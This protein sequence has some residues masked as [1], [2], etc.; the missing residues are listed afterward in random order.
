MPVPFFL[1][2]YLVPLFTAVLRA[3][4]E[5]QQQRGIQYPRATREAET[6]QRFGVSRSRQT[7]FS[8]VRRFA[9]GSFL[10]RWYLE[11]T[12]SS[13]LPADGRSNGC[14]AA[15]HHVEQVWLLQSN[16]PSLPIPKER[17]REIWR[18]SRTL[19]FLKWFFCQQHSERCVSVF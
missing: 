17:Q 14:W 3:T 6:Q 2:F 5:K 9:I 13:S 19:I 1:L 15:R 11:A 10:S 18:G 4:Q 8:F 12:M 16:F 7:L